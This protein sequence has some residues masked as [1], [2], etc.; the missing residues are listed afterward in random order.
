[1]HGPGFASLLQRHPGDTRPV[2]D[3]AFD[4]DAFPDL[5]PRRPG[6]VEE[7]GVEGEAAQGEAGPLPPA[8]RPAEGRAVGGDEP[9]APERPG[10][11]GADAVGR[12][13]GVEE[14]PGLGGDALAADLV[15]RE[16]GRLEDEHVVS[17]EG[18]EGR[19]GRAGRAAAHD[20]HLP[21]LDGHARPSRGWGALA[22]ARRR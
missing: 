9:H 1:M 21:P 11:E 5:G 4:P 7:H 16:A 8:V 17:P 22:T 3:E 12:A 10:G 14:P 15:A 13:H 19:R 18:Q 2:P 20:D 6:R